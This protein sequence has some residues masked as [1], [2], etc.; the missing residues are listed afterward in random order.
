MSPLP[1]TGICPALYELRFFSLISGGQ[2]FVF[3]CDAQGQVDIGDLSERCRNDYFYARVVV[4]REVA[5]PC[6]AL[7]E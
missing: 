4:G 2:N 1:E 6:L 3:P 5:P 7:L